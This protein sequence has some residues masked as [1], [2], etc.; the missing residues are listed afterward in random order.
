V[1]AAGQ[2]GGEGQR[3]A[4]NLLHVVVGRCP[5]QHNTPGRLP[6]R[7]VN[8]VVAARKRRFPGECTADDLVEVVVARGPA[9]DSAG[10]G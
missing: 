10:P 1:P 9:Q 3:V 7:L 4:D 8:W 6:R 5:I 2:H